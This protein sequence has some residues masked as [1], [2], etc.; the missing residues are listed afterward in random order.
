M[1][2][3][4]PLKRIV[5][6]LENSPRKRAGRRLELKLKLTKHC[7]GESVAAS[8]EPQREGKA[9]H[10]A[11]YKRGRKAVFQA[12][13]VSCEGPLYQ[14]QAKHLLQKGSVAVPDKSLQYCSQF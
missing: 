7:C 8:G 14:P 13:A 9:K 2:A 5:D 12:G 6:I 11:C 1:G 10:T 4:G 3:T